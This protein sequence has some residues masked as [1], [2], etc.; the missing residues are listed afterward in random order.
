M[1]TR[2]TEMMQWSITITLFLFFI[3]FMTMKL[4]K[5]IHLYPTL[6]ILFLVLVIITGIRCNSGSD[7]YNY[8]TMYNDV[9]R[10]YQSLFEIVTARFQ[11]GYL[12]LCYLVKNTI[13]GD[14]TIFIIVS[15][16]IYGIVFYI[17]KKRALY[18]MLAIAC[19]LCFGFFDMSINIVKQSIAMSLILLAYD[20]YN[21]NKRG[22]FIIFCLLASMF[23]ISSLYV[24]LCMFLSK[25]I[26]IN[27]KTFYII[28]YSSIILLFL[29]T[30][31]TRY[32]LSMFPSF[33]Y[34]FYL[35]NILLSETELK[36]QLGAIIISLFYFFVIRNCIIKYDAIIKQSPYCKNMFG[37]ILLCIPILVLGIRY[38]MFNRVG[39]FGLQF[40]IFIFP[41]YIYSSKEIHLKRNYNLSIAI[42]L[43]FHLVFA[44]LA[45][46]NNYYSYSTIFNDEPSSI[47]DFVRRTD[48]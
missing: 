35:Q 29:L 19:W 7:Y 20:S 23:H 33:K 32:F 30:P 18:P 45:A 48:R 43:C 13:G 47:Y 31:M 14:H 24:I 10:W 11:N 41:I 8:Y 40:L 38:Y 21:E 27:K 5:H 44:V 36:L 15:I 26:K 4:K 42:L 34:A 12:M 16:I 3:I 25:Y 22:K 28:C 17:V 6:L 9:N 37:I 46:E 1:E 2:F 39:Y